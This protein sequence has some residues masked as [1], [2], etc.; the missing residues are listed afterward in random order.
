MDEAKTSELLGVPVE[1]AAIDSELRKIWESD[2]ASTNASL[3]NFLV[4]TEEPGKLLANSEAIQSLTRE[5]ACRAVLIAMDRAASEVS[6]QAWITAHCHLAHGKKSI[7]SEQIAFLLRGKALG[8]LRNTVFAHLNSDLPLVFWW[9][10]ELSDLFE[11]RLFRIL[12]RLIVDSATWRDPLDGY[13]KLLAARAESGGRMVVQD[14]A[15]TRSFFYRLAIARL[16]DDPVVARNLSEFRSLRLEFAEGHRTAAILLLAWFLV[17][18]GWKRVAATDTG[19]KV[20]NSDVHEITVAMEATKEG[21]PL[22][23]FELVSDDCKV[24]VS[25]DHGNAHLVQ[26][27]ESREHEVEFRGP[28]D[29][30]D[31]VGLVASQLSRGGKNSLFLSV[32]DEFLALLETKGA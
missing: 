24:R 5:H 26:K 10:G 23:C 1:V 12:N 25:R 20:E 32:M 3:M 9:Q 6:T 7:C 16:F 19:W 31:A 30:D 13:H 27:I 8:R 22:G 14:L 21:A 2:Q 28:A 15:W 17:R 18:A 29:S 11:E 4:Y